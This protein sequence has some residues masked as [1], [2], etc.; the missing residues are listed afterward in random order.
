VSGLKPLGINKGVGD[1]NLKVRS[2]DPSDTRETAVKGECWET[3]ADANL[4]VRSTGPAGLE[5]SGL[6]PLHN[7]NSALDANLKVR[8]TD[9][10]DTR[11]TAVKGDCWET[12]ADANL[13]V[14][15]TD[16]SDTRE[17]AAKG[18]CLETLAT[19]T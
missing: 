9:L 17:T 6:K 18:E 5:V 16:P 10:S 13:K 19:R 3:Q 12:Q 15:S 11:E 8:S 4:K 14:R 7:N 2:T 1:A